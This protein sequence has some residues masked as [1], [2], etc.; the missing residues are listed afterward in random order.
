MTGDRVPTRQAADSIRLSLRALPRCEFAGGREI[1]LEPKDAA[2]LAWLALEGPTPRAALAARLWPDADDARARA[3]LRQRLLRL[4][5]QIGRA[6][7]E[8]EAT[9]ALS[10]DVAHDLD[11]DG[12]LLAALSPQQAGGLGE[13]L[14]VTR[15]RRRERRAQRLEREAMQAEAAGDLVGGLHLAQQW[16]ELDPLAEPAHRLLMRLHYLRSDL[17]SARAAYERCAELLRRELGVAPSGETQALAR[18]FA[19]GA[20]APRVAAALPAT[21][22]RPPRLIGREAERNA[23][24]AAWRGGQA[25][26]VVGE[27]GMGKTRLLTDCVDGAAALVAARPGDSAVPYAAAARLLTAIVERTPDA[28]APPWAARLAP[29]LPAEGQA[30][31]PVPAPQRLAEDLCQVLARARTHGLKTLIVDDLHFADPASLELLRALLAADLPDISWGFAQRGGEVGAAECFD[32]L[33]E[34]R[35]LLPVELAPLPA[36]ALA[37]LID[38]LGVPTLSGAALAPALAKHC[39]GN[40][41][42]VLETLKHMLLEGAPGPALPQPATVTAL[43]ERRLQRL[44]PAALALARLAAVAGTDFDARLAQDVLGADALQLADAWAELEAAQVLRDAAFAHDLVYEAALAAVPNAI[45]RELHAR[46]A[47]ALQAR[48]AP[49]QRIARH[50]VAAGDARRSLPALRAAADA[51]LAKCQRPLAAQLLEQA[52][53]MHEALQDA[54]AAFACLTEAIQLRQSFDTGAAHEAATAKLLA[55]ARTPAQRAEAFTHRACYLLIL[56]RA[57]EAL[58]LTAQAVAAADGSGHA[59]ARAR[60][61]NMRGI[62]LRRLGQVDAAIS[63]LSEALKLA[64]LCDETGA[65]LPAIANNLALARAE[66]D[67]HVDAILH[68]EEAARRQTDT[69][70]RARVLNNLAISLEEI[71]RVERAFETRRDALAL[72]R[73]QE[74]A[75]FAQLNLLVSLASCARHLQ[76]YTDALH[77]LE[78]AESLAVSVK[79]W[80]VANLFQERALLYSELGAWQAADAALQALENEPSTAG[81]P[82]TLLARVL[83][84]QARG[85]DADALLAQ[86]AR[87]CDAR[88]ERRLLRRVRIAQIRALAPAAALALAQQELEYAATHGQRSAQIP[89]A[90][91]AAQAQ[92]ALGDAAT[93]RALAARAIEAARTGLRPLAFSMFEVRLTWCEARAAAGEDVAEELRR[94]DDELGALAATQ[95]PE[96]HRNM[97]LRGVPLH[98]RIRAAAAAADERSRRRALKS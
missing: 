19:A 1:A 84:R 52:A 32:A 37:A 46:V 4:R 44:S 83:Y 77:W 47:D 73:A 62:A 33:I 58:P 94:L 72:L 8:G 35:R 7:L 9:L 42:F 22:L 89:F 96:A 69:P 20:P 90:T 2:M 28:L 50:R 56:G 11:D 18:H 6:V 3:N 49:A 40:P 81:Q 15:Q 79:H 59:P 53:D 13:W 25:V 63:V 30:A 45:A 91:L 78:Q 98:R 57:E 87:A 76:R 36:S 66:A 60:A 68:F 14:E 95:V 43:I 92:L 26:L 71:G 38:S 31:S 74:G 21:V 61:L 75:E 34:A 24:L 10:A 86:L 67:D 12:E 41:L 70:T 93:A 82:E 51:A 97:F 39:G 29:L 5:R 27:A 80:R 17:V 55:L 64:R 54:D 85:I 88:S 16:L 48:G 65:D 23:I